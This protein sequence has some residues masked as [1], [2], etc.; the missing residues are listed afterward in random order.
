MLHL[1]RLHLQGLEDPLGLLRHQ[2]RLHPVNLLDLV[3]LMDL[4]GLL[5]LSLQQYRLNLPVLVNQ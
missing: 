1:N 4:L 5:G 2:H 3:D